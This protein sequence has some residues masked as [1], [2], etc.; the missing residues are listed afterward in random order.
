MARLGQDP[1]VFVMDNRV[2]AAEQW[3]IN[4]NAFCPQHPPPFV[5][6]TMLPQGHIWDDVKLAEGSGGQGFTV[7]TTSTTARSDNNSLYFQNGR[8]YS[9]CGTGER[10]WVLQ[11][12]P[13]SVGGA[14]PTT[15]EIGCE[16]YG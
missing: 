13:F 14:T 9:P 7:S 11:R 8:W 1:I 12:I 3:L 6:L 15:Y 16:R 5:P 10:Y 2:F 4:A